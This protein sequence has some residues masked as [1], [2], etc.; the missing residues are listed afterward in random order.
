[1]KKM[2]QATDIKAIT[3]KKRPMQ[4]IDHVDMSTVNVLI[5]KKGNYQAQVTMPKFSDSV[6]PVE[7][8]SWAIKVN[9]VFRVHNYREDKKIVMAS[10]EF[11]AYALIW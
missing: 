4:A 11:K 9:K 8:L 7:Y 10:F 2:R 1:M 5:K 6:V 3:D